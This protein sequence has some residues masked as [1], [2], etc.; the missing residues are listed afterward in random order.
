MAMT[1]RTKTPRALEA[2]VGYFDLVADLK[3]EGCPVCHGAHRA[4]WRYLDSLLWEHVNDPDIRAKLRTSFG[5]CR[6]H[7]M[8]AISVA[9]QQSAALGMA[10]LY[11]D[12]L[13]SVDRQLED[14][15]RK[16]GKERSRR[17]RRTGRSPLPRPA[18]CRVCASGRNVE[19]NYLRLL[20]SAPDDSPIGTGIREPGRGLCLHHTL[21]GLHR[22]RSDE[23]ADRLLACFT[24]GDREL[25]GELRE[26]IRKQDYRF[27]Q[28]G[29]T[30]GEVSAWKRAVFRVVGEPTS[31]KEPS[32]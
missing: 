13:R 11:E 27:Q 32:R 12:F 2:E 26:F 19:E 15:V 8:M 20:A 6:E 21:L 16:R 24:H 5:F 14:A 28:E 29:L 30:H 18:P 22:V 9:G 1:R 7:S 10:I 31:R 17:L 25:R 4:A 3:K 23:H